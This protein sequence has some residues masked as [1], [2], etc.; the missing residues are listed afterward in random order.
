M[1][2]HGLLVIL[3]C[4]LSCYSYFGPYPTSIWKFL[5]FE[6]L[7]ELLVANN[8]IIEIQPMDAI[9]LLAIIMHT[10]M[11]HHCTPASLVVVP[12]HLVC[13]NTTLCSC[14]LPCAL[15]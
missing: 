6:S 4:A 12:S 9:L 1:G 10:V 8:T 7:A 11:R 14:M 15:F 13:F 5:S 2:L 3:Y